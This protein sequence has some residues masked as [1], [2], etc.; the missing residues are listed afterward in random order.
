LLFFLIIFIYSFLKS[1]SMA[2][3]PVVGE[4]AN[5]T[6][7]SARILPSL[8]AGVPSLPHCNIL[9]RKPLEA[10]FSAINGLLV[11]SRRAGED[12]NLRPHSLLMFD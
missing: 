10:M 11:G 5:R 6:P 7:T 12:L 1:F 4:P 8:P 9:S 3:S 2:G